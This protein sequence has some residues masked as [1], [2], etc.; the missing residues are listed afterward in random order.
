[1]C[2]E[3]NSA[4]V[5]QMRTGED[6][7]QIQIVKHRGLT[8]LANPV[9]TANSIAIIKISYQFVFN[10]TILTTTNHNTVFSMRCNIY[11]LHLCYNVSVRVSVRLSVTEVHCGHSA[12]RE[13]RMG[14]F[15]LC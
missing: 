6:V 13:E 15:A 8:F 14:H 5:Y 3:Q 9:Y 2:S 4:E 1:M 12:C 11:I 7:F 10:E